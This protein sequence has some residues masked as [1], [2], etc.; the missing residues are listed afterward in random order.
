M[1]QT[2]SL[3]NEGMG[4][5][6][7]VMISEAGAAPVKSMCLLKTACT[8]ND[9]Q[10]SSGVTKCTESGLTLVDADSVTSE[11]TTFDD[12]TI[13]IYKTFTAGASAAVLGAGIWCDDDD[14]LIGIVCF[15]A[16]VNMEKN[17][18]LKVTGKI[19][20]TDETA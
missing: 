16:A 15:N 13:Q 19:V 17:D 2:Q 18:T 11:K 6:V 14:K 1:A 20:I 9:S 12:D 4:E 8:A 7:R 3:C 5:L 10:T